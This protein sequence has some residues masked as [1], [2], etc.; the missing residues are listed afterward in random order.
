M[1]DDVFYAL[2]ASNLPSLVLIDISSCS[3][4]SPE[5]Q[6]TLRIELPHVLVNTEHEASKKYQ[7]P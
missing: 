1:R 6:K 7:M 3:Q 2:L 5:V 4:L